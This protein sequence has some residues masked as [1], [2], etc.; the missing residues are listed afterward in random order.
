MKEL[1]GGTKP[2]VRVILPVDEPLNL[3]ARVRQGGLTADLGGLWLERA[4]FDFQVTEGGTYDVWTWWPHGQDRA[5]DTRFTILHGGEPIT[6][7]VDQRDFGDTWF[8]LDTVTLGAGGSGSIVVEGSTTGYA[9]A[10]AIALTPAGAG[11]PPT[12]A[13]DTSPLLPP[14]EMITATGTVTETPVE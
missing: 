9:N 8:W 14:T 6:V 7:T 5:S 2:D 12:P 1:F 3:E 13:V 4:R 11:P 10:D